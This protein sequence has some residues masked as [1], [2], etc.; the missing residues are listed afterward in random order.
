V[1]AVV[2]TPQSVLHSQT[3]PKKI[4]LLAAQQLSPYFVLS[5]LLSILY[6]ATDLWVV[7]DGHARWRLSL[8]SK[9]ETKRCL[10]FGRHCSFVL[11]R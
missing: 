5:T 6:N 2:V 8:W 11:W 7:L 3:S 10:C 1:A 9:Q 4:F